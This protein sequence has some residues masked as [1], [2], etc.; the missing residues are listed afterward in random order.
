[1]QLH[2]FS[3]KIQKS[4]LLS[5]MNV[6]AFLCTCLVIYNSPNQVLHVHACSVVADSVRPRELW[7]LPH[8]DADSSPLCKRIRLPRWRSGKESA[9]QCRRCWVGKIPWN[10]KWLSTPVFLPVKSQW[11]MCLVGYSSWGHKESDT[12]EQLTL[13]SKDNLRPM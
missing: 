13:T 1:M 9:C 8:W 7:C 2:P 4:S 11:Q 12:T 5:K 6:H 3:S 10:R